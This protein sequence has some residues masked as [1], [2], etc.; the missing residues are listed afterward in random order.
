VSDLTSTEDQRVLVDVVKEFA[1]GQVR[2]AAGD[3]DRSCRAPDELMATA[4]GLGIWQVSV[5]EALGGFSGRRSPVTGVLVAETL[6]TGDL[7]L[8]VALLAP[9]AVST[10]LSLWGD[11]VQQSTYLPAFV[12]DNPPRAAL[13]ISEPQPLF[14]PFRLST[15]A[16][17]SGDSYVLDGV[18]SMVPAAG[19][20]KLFIVAAVVSDGTS[21]GGCGIPALF[22]VESGTPGLTVRP[23]P[24]TGLRAAET[25]QLRLD[26]VRV[27]A[28]ALLSGDPVA[29]SPDD[30]SGT[31][32]ASSPDGAG[33]RRRYAYADC[34]RL[35]RLGWCALAVG[36]G[37]AVL[38]YVV[39][40]IGD[41]VTLGEPI[42]HWQGAAFMIADLA[43]ELDGMRLAT[44][45][46]AA[47]AEQ[48]L[49]FSRET[50]LARRLCSDYG[51]VIG[52]DGIQLLG[53]HGSVREHPVERWYRD[54]RV[55][56]LMEGVVLV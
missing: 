32:D 52:S 1:A 23:E 5:P 38:D 46:A 11:A 13:A 28:S 21:L 6:A 30:P 42:S 40:Y 31:D 39:P 19:R 33:S 18:K 41:R 45:R 12:G 48:G 14:D 37:Q 47:R 17:R 44:Y 7:G 20:A 26:G 25:G 2:P 55:I 56:G 35:A 53:G 43:T 9:A 24:A 27:P 10:A 50:V 22:I 15:R 54:L 4:A 29:S 16:V 36:T 3:A 8:A 51:S 34:I 49:D